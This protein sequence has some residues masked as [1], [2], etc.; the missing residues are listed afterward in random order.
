MHVHGL[1]SLAVPY[2]VGNPGMC[3]QRWS[4]VITLS[5]AEHSS[6]WLHQLT[7][8][9]QF[10][11]LLESL[12][13]TTDRFMTGSRTPSGPSGRSSAHGAKPRIAAAP[14][15]WSAALRVNKDIFIQA[16]IEYVAIRPNLCLA[17]IFDFQSR[18][19]PRVYTPR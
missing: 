5:S 2:F 18:A 19:E 3:Q 8:K 6:N 12:V 9:S 14:L 10:S 15:V 11:D 17:Y 16:C 7:V 13:V 1:N 4:Q